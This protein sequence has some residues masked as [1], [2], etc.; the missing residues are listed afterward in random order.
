M[1][2]GSES[3]CGCQESCN[4]ACESACDATCQP[5]CQSC[6]DSCNA[7]CQE[8]CNNMCDQMCNQ[9]CANACNCSSTS[10]ALIFGYVSSF[11]TI[12]VSL[13]ILGF[14]QSFNSK[15]PILI[16]MLGSCLLAT[17][18]T[19]IRSNSKT[20][21]TNYLPA[22]K[23]LLNSIETKI[24]KYKFVHSHHSIKQREDGHE[25]RI[26]NKFF[27]TGCYGIFIG[28][29]ISILIFNYYLFFNPS[30]STQIMTIIP[31]LIP[32]S[33][34]PIIVRYTILARMK[35]PL[36]LLANILLPIGCSFVLISVDFYFKNWFLNIFIC[37]LIVLTAFAR[38]KV[39]NKDN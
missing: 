39:G 18:L 28:T 8:S 23:D 14:I 1:S 38:S 31:I 29:L 19:G 15:G 7:A 10:N 2:L 32:I 30:P 33:F 21:K 25:F 11:L 3:D 37:F 16:T 17:S 12:I 26:G 9:M 13:L 20:C 34:T 27:C 35:T 22:K 4:N 24:W 5:V 6:G 36:R